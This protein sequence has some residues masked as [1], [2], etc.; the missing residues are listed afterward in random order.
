MLKGVLAF[1]FCEVVVLFTKS[2]LE[3]RGYEFTR[4]SD[5]STVVNG[6]FDKRPGQS[7]FD[8]EFCIFGLKKA[9]SKESEQLSF[10]GVPAGYEKVRDVVSYIDSAEK[11]IYFWFFESPEQALDFFSQ[12][13]IWGRDSNYRPTEHELKQALS[14]KIVR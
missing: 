6:S 9:Y 3:E 14:V 12:H 11:L 7:I 4:P 13:Y 2:F 10:F 1:L 5:E 8:G